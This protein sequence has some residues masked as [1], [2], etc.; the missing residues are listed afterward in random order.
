MKRLRFFV[1]GT[2]TE[3]GKTFVSS[4]LLRG[5]SQ[6]GWK[7]L[8]LKP[9]AAGC[10]LH[11]GQWQNEDALQ[12]MAAMSM[13]LGYGQVNPIAL[14]DPI[15][16]HL[17]AAKVGRQL[18]AS[19]LVGLVRGACGVEAEMALVEG[20]GGWLVPLNERETLADVAIE[21]G[22]PV[23]LVV[24][25]R[26]GC[27]NHALLTYQAIRQ[28]GLSVCGWVAN[29]L[30]VDTPM[31]AENIATLEQRL[32]VPLLGNIPYLSATASGDAGQAPEEFINFELLQPD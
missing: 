30:A 5:F 8:G 31:G 19:R 29:T 15:A 26:L 14:P 32:P 4:A 10:E 11:E 23:I 22:F 9:V 25:I 1:T 7:T 28:S 18:S 16:P 13:E 24:G 17:A 20:A 2:D 27:L 6:R 21:L 12:L 3:V